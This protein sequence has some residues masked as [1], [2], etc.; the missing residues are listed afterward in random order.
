[1]RPPPLQLSRR[2]VQVCILLA[3]GYSDKGIARE[4]H[5][6]ANCV[7]RHLKLACAKIRASFPHLVV[8]GCGRR[9]TVQTWYK[10][11]RF[12]AYFSKRSAA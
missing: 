3:A 5:I 9:E 7:K 8:P 6:S 1:M 11:C 4:L 12:Q 2:Q 10:E